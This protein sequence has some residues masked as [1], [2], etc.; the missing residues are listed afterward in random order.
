MTEQ[1]SFFVSGL[2]V[3]QGSMKAITIKNQKHTQLIATNDGALKAWR[4]RVVDVAELAIAATG[5]P[6]DCALPVKVACRFLLPMPESRLKAIRTQG[7][8]FARY[9]PDLDKLMRAIGDALTDADVVID[10]SRIVSL[11]LSKYEVLEDELCGVEVVVAPVDDDD[12][13]RML[14][15]LQRRRTTPTLRR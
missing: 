2:P 15:V 3:P 14:A 10:D 5:W 12:V 8:D 1:L 13:G 9:P 6:L 7:I 4:K 11:G